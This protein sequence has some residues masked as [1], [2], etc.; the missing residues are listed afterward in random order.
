MSE[1]SRPSLAEPH[2][3]RTVRLGLAGLIAGLLVACTAK[4][5]PRQRVDI[6]V[7]QDGR[8]GWAGQDWD[9]S[10]L[11]QPL[12]SQLGAETISVVILAHPTAPASSLQALRTSLTEAKVRHVQLGDGK[13]LREDPEEKGF[14]F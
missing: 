2:R 3:A 12:A 5:L 8:C 13:A 10:T 9:C 14:K 7:R 4:D 11:G 6:E 1:S